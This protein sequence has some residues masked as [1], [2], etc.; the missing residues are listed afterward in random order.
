[1][2]SLADPGSD[3]LDAARSDVLAA[4][5]T[6]GS[7]IHANPWKRSL[8]LKAS[9]PDGSWVAVK[10]CAPT[11]P[12]D[13]RG[14]FIREVEYYRSAG[15]ESLMPELVQASDRL[16]ITRWVEGSV[17]R[18][19]LR[20]AVGQRENLTGTLRS[21]L[22]PIGAFYR[23][24]MHDGA[25]GVEGFAD[26]VIRA[27]ASL[28]GSGPLATRRTRVEAV[29]TRAA[30][31]PM[32]TFVRRL[33]ARVSRRIPSL[34]VTGAA[35]GD[36]HLDNVHLD[37][38]GEVHLLDYGT[39]ARDGSPAGD[40]VYLIATILVL[41]APVPDAGQLV[42]AIV[43]EAFGSDEEM[44]HG[45]V[46]VARLIAPAG[47]MN[48]RFNSESAPALVAVEGLRFPFETLTS[49]LAVAGAGGPAHLG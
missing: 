2:P 11:A 4:G 38:S 23:D 22:L 35:H 6:P 16:L 36:L 10:W 21:L 24:R 13:V 31:Y 39:A 32:R 1:V 42:T 45:L 15:H 40:L 48:R 30:A 44:A 27:Y 18:D 5:I 29:A 20:A 19:L 33:V 17:A 14:A 26:A 7:L 8:V 34:A 25:P 9:M 46:A 37:P 47:R 49:A 3:L 41:L 28:A 12:H 43:G